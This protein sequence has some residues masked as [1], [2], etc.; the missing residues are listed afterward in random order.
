MNITKRSISEGIEALL[1]EK[2]PVLGGGSGYIMPVDYMGNDETIVTSARV[3][4]AKGTSKVRG[5]KELIRFLLRHRHSSPFEMASVTFQM[6]IPLFANAQMVRHRKGRTASDESQKR[7]EESG[8]YSVLEEEYYI[9]EPERMCSQSKTN[10]QQSGDRLPEEVASKL[11][12][13]LETKHSEIYKF[14]RELLD[15]GLARELSRTVLSQAQYIS[16]VFQMDAHNLMHFMKLRLGD[17]AQYEIRVYAQAMA[18]VFKAWLPETHDAWEEYCLNAVTMS[19]TEMKFLR[20]LWTTVG[21]Q[22]LMD[23]LS[24]VLAGMSAGEK[25]EFMK[26]IGADNV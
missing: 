22:T 6:R 14:Y 23:S 3:S 25:T 7:N 18:D 8:R 21:G 17:D 12:S 26:K 13:D 9:P 4:Y 2:V 10:K 5:T 16:C 19:A 1:F 24:P 20:S 15:Q 11:V